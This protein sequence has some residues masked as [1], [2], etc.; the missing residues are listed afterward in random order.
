MTSLVEK[1][2]NTEMKTWHHVSYATSTDE[3]LEK[4][5]NSIFV[6]MEAYKDD[7]FFYFS[8]FSIYL[9]TVFCHMYIETKINKLFLSIVLK[10][11]VT[12]SVSGF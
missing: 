12:F 1:N 3:G 2:K 5:G 6:L 10:Y 7:Y 11:Q 9:T 4:S 8:V